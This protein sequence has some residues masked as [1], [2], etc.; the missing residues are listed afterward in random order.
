M[1]EADCSV[2]LLRSLYQKTAVAFGEDG[3]GKHGT[4]DRPQYY[5]IEDIDVD[6]NLGLNDEPLGMFALK[7]EGYES[8]EF[9]HICSDQN[10]LISIRKLLLDD[11][12][13]PDCITYAALEMQGDDYVAFDFDVG[14]ML[15]WA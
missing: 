1:I 5:K 7:L 9:G 4:C 3:C 14:L 6:I 13:D 10:F 15:D 11:H 2:L 8:K 12:I